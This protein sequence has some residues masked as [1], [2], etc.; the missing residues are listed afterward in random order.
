MTQII[1]NIKKQFGKYKIIQKKTE[2]LAHWYSSESNQQGL[3]NEKQHDRVWDGFQKSSHPCAFLRKYSALE[4]LRMIL[5][6]DLFWDVVKCHSETLIITNIK[7]ILKNRTCLFIL[8]SSHL[9]SRNVYIITIRMN[10]TAQ[11]LHV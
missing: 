3:S 11:V 7:N 10:V 8:G 5:R 9:F 4:G 6:S 1:T 2:T